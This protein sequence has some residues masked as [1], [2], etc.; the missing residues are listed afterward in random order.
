MRIV[1]SWFHLKV[2]KSCDLQLIASNL[3]ISM[4]NFIVSER[5]NFWSTFSFQQ[6]TSY[7]ITYALWLT[8][9]ESYFVLINEFSLVTMWRTTVQQKY[10][11]VH[12]YVHLML[13]FMNHKI[14][15]PIFLTMKPIWNFFAKRIISNPAIFTG[16]TF[17]S[18]L[19]HNSIMT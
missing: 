16:T 4:A 1:W 2:T 8:M 10:A 19:F 12:F 13:I 6:L 18:D 9:N 14:S 5:M 15:F 7:S 17:P 3:R 11:R